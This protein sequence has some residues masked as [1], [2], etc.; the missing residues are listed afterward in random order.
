MPSYRRC[1]IY[2][3][4]GGRS[5]PEIVFCAKL[6]DAVIIGVQQSDK[7]ESRTRLL[8]EIEKQEKDSNNPA[9][10]H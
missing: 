9:H 6:R 8:T 4:R 7:R 1:F 10:M 5:P 3:A 2:G